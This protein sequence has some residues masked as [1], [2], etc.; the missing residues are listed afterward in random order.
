VVLTALHWRSII[1]DAAVS[2]ITENIRTRF[3]A[4]GKEMELFHP[5]IYQ[6]YASK[7]EDVFAGYG[8]VSRARL[9]KIKDAYDPKGL[10]GK[11]I[12]AYFKV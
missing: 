3:T 8:A 7:A 4:V 10:F 2:V 11:R 9:R 6:N 1:D 5:Y 12:P